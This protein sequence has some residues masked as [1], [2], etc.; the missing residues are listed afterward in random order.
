[1][2]FLFNLDNY[3][4]WRQLT[5][6]PNEL[7]RLWNRRGKHYGEV[8]LQC[9]KPLFPSVTEERITFPRTMR[10]KFRNSNF[11]SQTF[12]FKLDFESKAAILASLLWSGLNVSIGV[13]C[14]LMLIVGYDI[15]TGKADL[16]YLIVYRYQ[17]H[18]ASELFW[19]THNLVSALFVII[20][21]ISTHI[22]N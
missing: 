13:K 8:C 5:W 18:V 17:P 19:L 15:Y 7:K 11:L 1:M 12:T 14:S 2:W 4:I 20:Q 16:Y 9:I 22:D 3:M 6:T 10:V 21:I